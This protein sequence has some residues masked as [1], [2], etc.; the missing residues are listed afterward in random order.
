MRCKRRNEIER[1]SFCLDIKG[2]VDENNEAETCYILQLI[3]EEDE[4]GKRSKER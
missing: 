3:R 1:K 4:E 2:V